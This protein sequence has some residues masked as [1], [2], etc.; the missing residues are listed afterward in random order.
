MHH[1]RQQHSYGEGEREGERAGAPIK[2][3]FPFKS[4]SFRSR[5]PKAKKTKPRT[6]LPQSVGRRSDLVGVDSPTSC[7]TVLL[8]PDC[9]LKVRAPPSAHEPSD[10][11]R[12][13]TSYPSPVGEETSARFRRPRGWACEDHVGAEVAKLSSG[14]QRAG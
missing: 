7:S 11:V 2:H 6:K 1:R 13:A 12:S 8:H 10:E 9:L 4:E 14:A 3:N 5:Q